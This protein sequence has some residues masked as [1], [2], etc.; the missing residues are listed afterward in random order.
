MCIE[1]FFAA[2]IKEPFFLRFSA[3]DIYC[4][5]TQMLKPIAAHSAIY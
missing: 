5:R 4:N 3:F 1:L 2:Q